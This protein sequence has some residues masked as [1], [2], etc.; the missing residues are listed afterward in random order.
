MES[1]H[2][3]A[4]AIARAHKRRRIEGH[5]QSLTQRHS[6]LR[7]A[8]MNHILPLESRGLFALG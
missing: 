8:G 4:L 5:R 2:L 7:I 6:P 1:I 3:G